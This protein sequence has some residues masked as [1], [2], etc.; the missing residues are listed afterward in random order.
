MWLLKHIRKI[1]KLFGIDIVR[2][3][4]TP[5]ARR[6][7]LIEQYEINLI[8]DVGANSGQYAKSTMHE[9]G[10]KGNIVSFEPL[11]EAYSILKEISEKYKKWTVHPYALG[12]LNCYK[13][14]NIAKNSYS[15]SI[16]GMLDTHINAAPESIY[17]GSEEIQVKTLD[18]IFKEL[19]IENKNIFLKIDTQ[20]YESKV[21][22]GAENS[23]INIDTIQIEMSLVPLYEEELT[24]T[25]MCQY[26]EEKGY[27]LVSLEPGFGDSNSGQLLQVDGIFR[28]F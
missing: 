20:G 18:S 16:L 25:K 28:R 21:L 27:T 11:A 8:L 1:S 22:K 3:V 12:D 7:K 15:S 5:K 17:I 2:Y 14:I 13:N 19:C 24:F 9:L 10:Y 4:S 6:A 23:L 26:L